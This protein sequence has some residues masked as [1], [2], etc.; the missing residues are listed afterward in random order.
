MTFKLIRIHA[1]VNFTPEADFGLFAFAILINSATTDIR[2]FKTAMIMTIPEA[3]LILEYTV[4]IS[5]V[6]YACNM[7]TEK[8]TLH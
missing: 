8:S 5:T 6:V 7:R 3:E 2:N 4:I 1:N